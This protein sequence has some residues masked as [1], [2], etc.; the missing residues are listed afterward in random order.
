MNKKKLNS[1]NS[2]EL[3]FVVTSTMKEKLAKIAKNENISLSKL[4]L[5]VLQKFSDRIKKRYCF[6]HED[7]NVYER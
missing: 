4:I 7:E 1:Q 2:H 5:Y 3:H 6:G